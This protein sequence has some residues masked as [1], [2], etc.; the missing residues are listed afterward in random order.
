M[1]KTISS[2]FIILIIICLAGSTY[3]VERSVENR[4]YHLSLE[5]LSKEP[6]SPAGFML[7]ANE[8]TS[9]TSPAEPEGKEK[10][11][12]PEEKTEPAKPAPKP[13]KPFVPSEKVK[14]GQSVDF[15]YDI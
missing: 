8:Q 6:T 15:P 1:A 9:D 4:M 5:A 3:A 10:T 2:T 7:A 12:A 11:E 13:R 14:A